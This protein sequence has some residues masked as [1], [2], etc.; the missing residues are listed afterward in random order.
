MKFVNDL[1]IEI[2][3]HNEKQ[4][5]LELYLDYAQSEEEPGPQVTYLDKAYFE[6]LEKYGIGDPK[7]YG[8]KLIKILLQDSKMAETFDTALDTSLRDRMKLRIRL[9]IADDASE[10]HRIHWES[11]V[12][13]GG[14]GQDWLITNESVL[15][16]RFIAARKPGIKEPELKHPGRLRALIAIA[17]PID[18]GVE[19][20]G[21]QYGYPDLAKIDVPG[22]TERA[23][24]AL[25]A[26][27]RVDDVSPSRVTRNILV[28]RLRDGYDILYLVCHGKTDE[29]L[30]SRIWLEKDDGT[31]D[32]TPINELVDR[33][34]DLPDDLKPRLIVLV[35][36]DSGAGILATDGT[37]TA[38][39][40]ALACDGR[41]PA[42]VAMGGSINVEIAEKFM[43]RFLR[44]LARHGSI[45]HAMASAR[46]DVRN[47][48]GAWMPLLYMRLKNG[49]IWNTGW[50]EADG[51]QHFTRLARTLKENQ[52]EIKKNK[53]GPVPIIGPGVLDFFTGPRG[54]FSQ[55]WASDAHVP[56][57][58]ENG[59]SLPQ[60][61]Q[62]ILASKTRWELESSFLD[63]VRKRIC[64]DYGN[65][66]TVD[67]KA[68]DM[69]TLMK[70]L[71]D[72]RRNHYA[73]DCPMVQLAKLPFSIYVTT[74]PDTLLAEALRAEQRPP[75]EGI[76]LWNANL[77]KRQLQDNDFNILCT[78]PAG[79]RP[80]PEEP[81][82]YYLFGRIDEPDTLVLAEDD[83]FDYLL[84]ITK[85]VQTAE[86]V[87][88]TSADY[89]LPAVVDSGLK[90]NSLIFLGFSQ[91]DWA[92]RVLLRSLV[93]A[94]EASAQF[95]RALIAAQ[96]DTGSSDDSEHMR[97]YLE[98]YFK[99]K[100][101][102]IYWGPSLDF[103][104]E[105]R[106]NY[107]SLTKQP[108]GEL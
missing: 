8:A 7:K 68:V 73:N 108:G 82:V 100:K 92:F 36:C 37:L 84:E 45:D 21:D 91:D 54:N 70:D 44:E 14:N 17:N 56:F 19:Q 99:Y 31:S 67:S 32:V 77:R 30:G 72:L 9:Y 3:K 93:S 64:E 16:S 107:S 46:G 26:I 13:P 6:T 66:L 35:S 4:Y 102:S 41:I 106:E 58:R 57:N 11:L 50:A 96:L 38:L 69:T 61:A 10:L 105:L 94:D 42:V 24:R 98:N 40:P 83:F 12:M 47:Y 27:A 59:D 51:F 85:D 90:L 76:Y 78:L 48:P 103:V 88:S 55:G 86:N 75:Q 23:K 71:C 25:E 18:L 1:L 52:G 89:L 29:K 79:Y 49:C 53:C 5:R 43:P 63:Y 20:I 97:K 15:F 34:K 80:T 65:S 104:R 81:L 87:H 39:G 22:E 95:S 101:I 28:E 74:N 33:I 60:V 2:S 62:Y